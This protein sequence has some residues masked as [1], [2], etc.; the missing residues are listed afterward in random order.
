[1]E[2]L[3]RLE[4]VLEIVQKKEGSWR[5]LVKNRMAPQPVYLG[6]K[7]PRWRESELQAYLANPAEF[8]QKLQKE[9]ENAL[10][11]YGNQPK[12]E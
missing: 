10:Q 12:H 2:T 11:P 7:S 9:A 5:Q 1:M 3:H 4:K 6:P 8:V